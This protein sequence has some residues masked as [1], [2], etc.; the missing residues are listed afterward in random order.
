MVIIPC[1]AV[2]LRITDPGRGGVEE[3]VGRSGGEGRIEERGC[4][5]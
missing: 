4:V 2:L 3:G 1:M 5:G